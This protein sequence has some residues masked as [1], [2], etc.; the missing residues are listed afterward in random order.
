MFMAGSVN[1]NAAE[2]NLDSFSLVHTAFQ[3]KEE[4]IRKRLR[5]DR[6]LTPARHSD[7][8]DPCREEAPFA[9]GLDTMSS[10]VWNP[11]DLREE[12]R[13]TRKKSKSDVNSDDR[14]QS[15]EGIGVVESDMSYNQADDVF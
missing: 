10:A 4:E 15:Y 12:K 13:L 2:V 9:K 3:T 6:L 8:A 7:S 5:S 14:N 11:S 1:E